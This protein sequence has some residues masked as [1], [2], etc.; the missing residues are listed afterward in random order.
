MEKQI[1]SVWIPGDQLLLDHPALQA[2]EKDYPREDICVVL[3]ES[4]ERICQLPYQ[5][6]K[7]VLLLSA[8]RHYVERLRTSGYQVEFLRA[9]SFV[10]GL[11]EH[12]RR[13]HP[14]RLLTMA[15]SEYDTRQLQQKHL[16]RELGIPV[17]VLPNSQFLVEFYNPI[18]HPQPGKRYVME[19]FYRAMRR[20]YGILLEGNG[21]P[22][23][24]QWNYDKLNREVLPP[25]PKLPPIPTF[26]P[27]PITQEVI[28][29]V[30]NLGHGVG[31]ARDF[32]MAVT[33]EQAQQLL[34]TFI[35]ERLAEFGPYEDAM[36]LQ[37]STLYHSQLSPYVNIGL[38]DPLDMVQAAEV[39]YYQNKAPIQSVEGFVRQ[40]LGWREY[41]YWQ[42]WQQM[43]G[44]RHANSWHGHR[45]MPQMFWNAQTDMKCI[46][47]IARRVLDTGYSNHIER[48]MVICNF[49]LLAG[50]DPYEVSNWFLS[51]YVDAY[52]WVVVPNVVG[53][54]MN[55]DEGHTATKPYI[56]SANYINKMSNY[57]K[58]CRYSHKQRSGPDA[59]PFNFLY[60]NFLTR[61]E[62]KLRSNPR[63]IQNVLSLRHIS[64]QEREVLA[65]EAERFLSQLA[66]YPATEPAPSL[67]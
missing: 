61:N 59:C 39:A 3:I 58:G 62:Q 7:L 50:I 66:Y 25:H 37:S 10:S 33:H 4:S 26:K 65:E 54:G 64:L 57:C 30:E 24:G 22:T 28:G 42:Y 47:H 29:L 51:C 2:A 16:S 21:E 9:D 12:V 11:L 44:L 14:V 1:I 8:M 13:L 46:Q 63:L 36:S 56:S 34:E 38:L 53:M 23:G 40:I 55:S 17:E 19:H 48:L 43:P 49:C 31:N 6:K 27:D 67:Q 45:Q 5:R 32:D 18:P 35:A 20:H 52:D 60:W 41:M 15:A